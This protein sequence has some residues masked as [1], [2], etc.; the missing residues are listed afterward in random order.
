MAEIRLSRAWIPLTVESVA[1]LGG[2]MGVYQLS[3]PEDE[4]IFIGYAGGRSVLGLRGELQKQLEK[5][6]VKPVWFRLEITTAYLSRYK[7]LLMLH[8]ADHGAMPREND[9]GESVGRLSPM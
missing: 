4:V 9:P 1:R 2:H 5:T 3:S 6:T 8:I 7:E